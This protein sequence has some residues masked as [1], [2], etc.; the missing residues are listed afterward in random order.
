MKLTTVDSGQHA[1]GAIVPRSGSWPPAQSSGQRHGA[2]WRPNG[3]SSR[4]M[5]IRARTGNL[6]LVL[7]PGTAPAQESGRG[8]MRYTKSTVM[9]DWLLMRQEFGLRDAWTG[10]GGTRPG[11]AKHISGDC[12]IHSDGCLKTTS[13]PRRTPV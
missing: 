11:S 3:P 4:Q 7:P 8:P 5:T 10:V 6:G 1:G 2:D 9:G 12:A 13:S